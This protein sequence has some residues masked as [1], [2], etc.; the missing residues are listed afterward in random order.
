MLTS[1]P[2]VPTLTLCSLRSAHGWPPGALHGALRR[3]ECVLHLAGPYEETASAVASGA[4]VDAFA[5]DIL[6]VN[7]P[8]CRV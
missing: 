2:P 8:A 1:T 4:V 6:V 7:I 3:A 5:T